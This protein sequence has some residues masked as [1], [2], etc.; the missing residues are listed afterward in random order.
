MVFGKLLS[1]ASGAVDA[2]VSTVKTAVGLEEAPA[3]KGAPAA[4]ASNTKQAQPKPKPTGIFGML[5]DALFGE[6]TP[7]TAA[8]TKPP[9]PPAKPAAKMGFFEAL[10]GGGAAAPA[11]TGGGK[12]PAAGSGAAAAAAAK[13]PAKPAPAKKPAA[14]KPAKAPSPP[15]KNTRTGPLVAGDFVVTTKEI[16]YRG[17]ANGCH[18]TGKYAAGHDGVVELVI[19]QTAWVR[20]DPAKVHGVD[21]GQL[22]RAE[23]LKRP[24]S[25]IRPLILS[26][27]PPKPGTK[28]DVLQCPKCKIALWRVFGRPPGTSKEWKCQNPVHSSGKPVLI[29]PSPDAPAGVCVM[30]N[31]GLCTGCVSTRLNR[32]AAEKKEAEEKRQKAEKKKKKEEAFAQAQAAL[33]NEEAARGKL[34]DESERM[35]RELLEG[36]GSVHCPYGHTMGRLHG[37]RGGGSRIQRVA[38]RRA[39]STP[40]GALAPTAA[41]LGPAAGDDDDDDDA[42]P[43]QDDAASSSSSSSVSDAASEAGAA[44]AAE[45][46]QCGAGHVET[47]SLCTVCDCVLC[48]ECYWAQHAER[49]GDDTA[50][51]KS[52]VEAGTQ[53]LQ[54]EH[55]KKVDKAKVR[56][57]KEV[58]QLEAEAAK[59]HKERRFDMVQEIDKV[60]ARDRRVRR[61]YE[62]EVATSKAWL[63]NQLRLQRIA[64]D[65]Q[66][67]TRI[68][69]RVVCGVQRRLFPDPK[70]ALETRPSRPGAAVAEARAQAVSKEAVPIPAAASGDDGEAEVLASVLGRGPAAAAAVPLRAQHLADREARVAAVRTFDPAAAREMLRAHAADDAS[71]DAS[72]ASGAYEGDSDADAAVR[73]IYSQAV[74]QELANFIED[75]E[76]AQTLLDSVP[77][78][79][80]AAAMPA[81]PEEGHNDAF[82]PML[83]WL[84]GL[85]A[86]AAS[87]ASLA[88]SVSYT[89]NQIRVIIWKARYLF[90]MMVSPDDADRE[91]YA[92]EKEVGLSDVP[93]LLDRLGILHHPAPPADPVADW[94]GAMLAESV[95]P[96]EVPDL[97]FA[98]LLYTID[99]KDCDCASHAQCQKR[100]KDEKAAKLP[101][102]RK[103]PEAPGNFASHGWN[104]CPW[105]VMN[106]SIRVA[107]DA[108]QEKDVRRV[109][110]EAWAVYRS[111]S[112]RLEVCLAVLP[113]KIDA[114]F[115]GV[116]IPG[117]ARRYHLSSSINWDPFSSTSMVGLE[118]LGYAKSGGTFFVVR[119]FTP[120][121]ISFMSWFPREAEALL[122]TFCEFTVVS[123]M[124]TTLLQMLGCKF[125]VVTMAEVVPFDVDD[126]VAV[127]AVQRSGRQTLFIYE[128]YLRHYIEGAVVVRDAFGKS[129]PHG[130]F[131]AAVGWLA[132]S[133]SRLVL[134]G[135]SGSGKTSA[136]LALLSY[137]MSTPGEL[138]FPVF[139][140]LPKVPGLWAD[141][142]AP[143]DDYI[144]TMLHLNAAQLAVLRRT[145]V[146][147]LLLDSLDEVP[148]PTGKDAAWVAA[149]CR[150]LLAQNPWARTVRAVVSCRQEWL[151][152][153]RLEPGELLDGGAPVAELQPFSR[154]D[155]QETQFREAI[156]RIL[157][158]SKKN[159]LAAWP[160]R[161]AACAGNAH[162]PPLLCCKDCRGREAALRAQLRAAA[163]RENPRAVFAAFTDDEA[164]QQKMEALVAVWSDVFRRGGIEALIT[165]PF[166]LYMAMETTTEDAQAEGLN[167]V[168]AAISSLPQ[169]GLT[170]LYEAY[171]LVALPNDE[172]AAFASKVAEDMGRRGVWADQVS[173]YV[174]DDASRALFE[175]LPV[176]TEDGEGSDAVFS[177][178]HKSLHEYLVAKRM[179]ADCLA[180]A[181]PARDALLE[182]FGYAT[183][184]PAIIK[185]FSERLARDDRQA[186]VAGHLG[187]WVRSGYVVGAS[188]AMSFL[189]QARVPVAEVQRDLTGVTI[190]KANLDGG[191]FR[192][193]TCKDTV[194][195]ECSMRYTDLNQCAFASADLSGTDLGA[196][197]G[198]TYGGDCAV[199]EVALSHDSRWVAAYIRKSAKDE[200][201]LRVHDTETG[202]EVLAVRAGVQWMAF[203]PPACGK[204]AHYLVYLAGGK[205][206]AF[207]LPQ[208]KGAA[209][210][211]LNDGIDAAGAVGATLVPSPNCLRVMLARGDAPESRCR[212]LDVATKVFTE[213]AFSASVVHFGAPETATDPP[214]L[215]YVTKRW[216]HVVDHWSGDVI[217]MHNCSDDV[218][219]THYPRSGL[220][221]ALAFSADLRYVFA[222][223]CFGGVMMYNVN[224]GAVV[225]RVLGENAKAR[226]EMTN[227]THLTAVPGTTL[228]ALSD[229]GVGAHI[230]GQDERRTKCVYI[231]DYAGEGEDGGELWLQDIE[232][233]DTISAVVSA[234]GDGRWLA[235][236]T[237]NQLRLFL[238]HPKAVFPNV[239][240]HAHAVTSVVATDRFVCGS[241]VVDPAYQEGHAFLIRDRRSGALVTPGAVKIDNR[242]QRAAVVATAGGD[243]IAALTD[244]VVQYGAAT[245]KECAAY[246]V[247][248]NE[249]VCQIALSPDGTQLLVLTEATACF[250]SVRAAGD[251]ASAAEPEAVVKHTMREKYVCIAGPR[252]LVGQGKKMAEWTVDYEQQTVKEV[253]AVELP[254][255]DPQWVE[256][257]SRG[258]V[259]ARA[260]R[261]AKN[262]VLD[263]PTRADSLRYWT[264]YDAEPAVY[265]GDAAAFHD[266]RNIIHCFAFHADS[267]YI[268]YGNQTSVTALLVPCPG[269]NELTTAEAALYKPSPAPVWSVACTP[270]GKTVVWG[271]ADGAISTANF[272]PLDPTRAYRIFGPSPRYQCR[273]SVDPFVANDEDKYPRCV[274][275]S[276][277][278]AGM[279][280]GRTAKEMNAKMKDKA[281]EREELQKKLGQS[282][283]KKLFGIF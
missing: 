194:I 125:S 65:A 220:V 256:V 13:P 57:D 153:H 96:D 221:G 263:A 154:E 91:A 205:V 63:S 116:N 113:K 166:L 215:A 104:A 38:K 142:G 143:L 76:R 10:L 228:L 252:I 184:Q 174:T 107:A 185:F 274:T 273:F 213:K 152:A 190:R 249:A 92:K 26:K 110:L 151:D 112:D 39:G 77:A 71:D 231:A 187:K 222:H 75:L 100:R 19:K 86:A 12:K 161:C 56:A 2:A 207:A 177:F 144:K 108:A 64:L 74:L 160:P 70:A 40:A 206:R 244:R 47:P 80:G 119:A 210:V 41:A 130:L 164:A 85:P 66:L 218:M 145:R 84:M 94:L 59:I 87:V 172:I 93:A 245:G 126:R 23:T 51:L 200:K 30:C 253:R 223:I 183:E 181:A 259:V 35:R 226:M 97:L 219:E 182:T 240:C 67:R 90:G 89:R 254:G 99:A 49:V 52:A 60:R 232:E 131:E 68:T 88:A 191:I 82:P 134:A 162:P 25:K 111:L 124:S 224:E 54:E 48:S 17:I 1:K 235:L 171:L 45:C 73:K 8:P 128:R 127:T 3:A 198:R 158:E 24:V 250:F 157:P 178:R 123:K 176:R 264:S 58:K 146:V 109:S 260:A 267:Q 98:C 29:T 186:L 268:L 114:L 257:S 135:L 15:P 34:R 193:V 276:P 136:S 61:D 148:I 117:L 138:L 103:R 270:D 37:G 46:S 18:F 209:C 129:A 44:M 149:R 69:A 165:N 137:F 21:V 225:R 269:V 197:V 133:N 204:Y 272:D 102:H 261:P 147:L 211:P 6:A 140:P 28:G 120:A 7:P 258:Q 62:L 242:R 115:R 188:N 95:G 275:N 20:F 281:R 14:K 121:V 11:S 201:N 155:V 170:E 118:A 234:A 163:A 236:G 72:D 167:T 243:F 101:D 203:T 78:G 4:A 50:W 168:H 271:S 241:S 208:E 262:A 150:A 237:S 179:F 16:L 202:R 43:T 192:A 42:L 195:A 22:Q 105:A 279:F 189:A 238:P 132:G 278:F 230:H 216:L 159:R 156:L 83:S 32:A 79:A 247:P 9:P 31:Y 251:G 199:T 122:S 265:G 53:R 180:E 36:M 229:N 248:A 246:A 169:Y 277:A 5:S 255:Y 239:A 106:W 55:R 214:L 227:H 173:R 280:H 282:E 33:A 196:R 266:R 217:F 175:Q 27:P 81:V 233:K 283:K 212:L 141:T 139:V